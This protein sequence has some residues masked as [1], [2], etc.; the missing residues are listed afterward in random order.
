M[1]VRVAST[2]EDT[3]N[4][5][6][7][8]SRQESTARDVDAEFMR[9]LEEDVRAVDRSEFRVFTDPNELEQYLSTGD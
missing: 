1:T 4:A 8:R 3:A 5:P 7:F 2:L 9:M 6:A